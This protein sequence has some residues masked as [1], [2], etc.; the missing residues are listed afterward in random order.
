MAARVSVGRS[1]LDPLFAFPLMGAIVAGGF[2][3]LIRFAPNND[4]L[5]IDCF[6]GPAVVLAGFAAASGC[7]IAR[8]RRW[9]SATPTG[10]VV[11]DRR[12]AFEFPDA[13]IAAVGSHRRATFDNGQETGVE[14]RCHVVIA[15]D[16]AGCDLRFAYAIRTGETDPLAEFFDRN[17]RRLLQNAW[18][19]WVAGREIASGDWTLSRT[20]FAY[21]GRSPVACHPDEFAAADVADGHVCIWLN[22]DP[23]PALRIPAATADAARLGELVGRV[24]AARPPAADPIDG[25]GRILFEW[26]RSVPW[27]V[28]LVLT[29]IL[30]PI[31]A[32]GAVTGI[33]AVVGL[34]PA[35][36]VAAGLPFVVL[37]RVALGAIWVR[38]VNVFRC[39][40]GGVSHRTSF[41][42]RRLRFADA[43]GFAFD[44]R[45]WR[46]RGHDRESR[47]AVTLDPVSPGLGPRITFWTVV[48]NHEPDWERFRDHISRALASAM[49]VRLTAGDPVGWTAGLQ[50]LPDG[51][52]VQPTAGFF[53]KKEKWVLPYGEIAGTDMQQGVFYVFQKGRDKSVFETPVSAPNFFPGFVLLMTLLAPDD[54]AAEPAPV[55]PPA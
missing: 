11:E 5:A 16:G 54:P 31:V 2:A 48:R 8:G 51:L 30:G 38:R 55:A 45:A 25:F 6:C 36:E 39:H 9:V 21:T 24:V 49:R 7:R 26:D 22:D 40:V 14:L 23:R 1:Y 32:G 10:L 41:G 44:L 34:Q 47:L 35:A 37:T 20:A 17:H 27:W 43:G 15:A 50:F 3:V 33:R 53:G 52:E 29:A 46:V 12:R 13:D 19:D 4:P 18:E 28:M 42:E